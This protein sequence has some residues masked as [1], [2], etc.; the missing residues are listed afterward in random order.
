[1]KYLVSLCLLLL[2]AVAPVLAQ[3]D[4]AAQTTALLENTAINCANTPLGQACFGDGDVQATFSD[5]ATLSAAG[6]TAALD[7]LQSIAVTDGAAL[8]HL[9]SAVSGADVKLLAVGGV[10]VADA[11]AS[12]FVTVAAVDVRAAAVSNLRVAPSANAL[13]QTTAALG[14]TLAADAVNADRTWV[15][16]LV[17]TQPL[18]VSASLIEG[19]V[20]G[21]PIV[22]D[23][24][25]AAFQAFDLTTDAAGCGGTLIAQVSNMTLLTINGADVRTNG[26]LSATARVGSFGALKV[27]QDTFNI[28]A[29]V[30]N[31]AGLPD[32][33][34]CTVTTISNLENLVIVN[35][36]ALSL[37]NGFVGHSLRCNDTAGVT[38]LTTPWQG[39]RP[40][41]A[42]QLAALAPFR[43]LPADVLF[44]ALNVPRTPPAAPVIVAAPNTTA[45]NTTPNTAPNAAP[46]TTAATPVVARPVGGYDCS[47]FRPTSPFDRMPWTLETQ[48]WWD[49]VA[50][51][52]YYLVVLIDEDGLLA[53]TF[54]SNGPQTTA[55]G[56]TINLPNWDGNKF[57]TFIWY[58][59]AYDAD[60]NLI[61][62]SPGEFV[63]RDGVP[64]IDGTP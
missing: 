50:G 24:S 10:T 57:N 18:W 48:F 44:Y 42:L 62:T 56:D 6:E 30:F 38:V 40:V 20:S 32:A 33:A 37:T 5:D 36:E 17:D 35:N 31:T 14:Q 52:A 28:F 51:A 47:N 27:D 4:C 59:E 15:R 12:P 1:M 23:A 16:V 19:D 34:Q 54:N 55:F 21:L 22:S 41:S 11:A 2:V 25:R 53:A 60:D 39:S 61:C 43:E 9:P 13:V 45:A 49:G 8:L 29:D 64:D 58:V 7:T 63:E 26:S 3:Q 46:N